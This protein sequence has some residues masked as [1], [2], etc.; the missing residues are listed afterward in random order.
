MKKVPPSVL[1]ARNGWQNTGRARPSFAVVPAPGQESVWDYPRP[2][3]LV[4]DP[5]EVVVRAGDLSVA[6]STRAIRILETASPPT[7][8]V[9]PGDVVGATLVGCRGS[10]H[11]EWKGEARYFALANDPSRPVAWSY[12]EP[13]DDFE[14]I[15]DHLCFYPSR[16]E[17]FV[18][19]IRVEAQPGEFYGGWVTPE[20]VGPFKGDPGSSGW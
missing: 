8:Y 15:R 16:V 4:P 18:A 17:C 13:F 2:P 11:C 9:P 6:R 10:S 7:F 1:A 20:I 14:T 12:P 5:R 19:G 3:A